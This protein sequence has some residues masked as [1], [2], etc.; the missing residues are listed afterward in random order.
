MPLRYATTPVFTQNIDF[1]LKGIP[2]RIQY[3]SHHFIFDKVLMPNIRY[4]GI[5]FNGRKVTSPVIAAELQ[6]ILHGF[7]LARQ[8]DLI[9]LPR[10]LPLILDK[11]VAA[12]KIHRSIVDLQ[13]CEAMAECVSLCPEFEFINDP[14]DVEVRVIPESISVASGRQNT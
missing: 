14:S 4:E 13:V 12:Y 8:Q 6:R 3:Y 5:T 9:Q 10:T 11:N 2:C 1:A 7:I